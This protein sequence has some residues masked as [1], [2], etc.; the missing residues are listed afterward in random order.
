MNKMLKNKKQEKE[1]KEIYLNLT[2]DEIVKIKLEE[3]TPNES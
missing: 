2:N 1:D 3:I